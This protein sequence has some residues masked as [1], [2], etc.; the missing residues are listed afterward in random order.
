MGSSKTASGSELD[1]P[2]R[3]GAAAFRIALITYPFLYPETTPL[4]SKPDTFVAPP[5]PWYNALSG[6]S[7]TL[8]IGL[9]HGLS[10]TLPSQANVSPFFNSPLQAS[11]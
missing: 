3:V 6:A 5:N 4:M 8:T 1:I 2:A 9:G 11:P 7:L 10:V